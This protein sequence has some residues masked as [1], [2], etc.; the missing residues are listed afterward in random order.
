MVDFHSHILPEIDDGS[1][2]VEMSLEM[3][4]KE[5][6]QGVHTVIAT[7]HFYASEHT[8]AQFLAGRQEAAERLRKA[9][10]PGL[11]RVLLG[12]EVAYFRGM[13]E[14]EALWDLRIADTNYILIELPMPP[15]NDR[16]YEELGDLRAKQNLLPIVAHVDR[17][18]PPF[19]GDR[20]VER[21]LEKDVLLQANTSFFLGKRA[22]RARRMLRE[23]TIH[24]LGSDCHDLS[25]R[26][27]NLGDLVLEEEALDH[28]RYHQQL[29]LDEG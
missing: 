14:S 1:T 23:G 8:P 17:Y 4:R 7:P 27:P 28:I 6:S 12:A 11:P 29:V 13:S 19:M 21:L 2:S 24:L 10:E 18:L 22:K 9:A 15:W 26:P 5:S 20:M 3:L 25:S 16:V